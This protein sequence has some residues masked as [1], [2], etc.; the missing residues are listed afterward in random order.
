MTNT[1]LHYFHF[2]L[3]EKYSTS[4]ILMLDEANTLPQK[5]PS[6]PYRNGLPYRI[7]NPYW[8]SRV[9]LVPVKY[10]NWY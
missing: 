3:K 9:F 1:K 7:S 4:V 5:G 10:K 8:T 6:L 2:I